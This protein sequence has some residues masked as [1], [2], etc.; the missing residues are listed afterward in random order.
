M[1]SELKIAEIGAVARQN[2]TDLQISMNEKIHE[3]FAGIRSRVAATRDRRSLQQLESRIGIQTGTLATTLIRLF[4][5]G[6]SQVVE[7]SRRSV[8]HSTGDTSWSFA[9]NGTNANLFSVGINEASAIADY[10]PPSDLRNHGRAAGGILGSVLGGGA[11]IALATAGPLGLIIGGL[12][13]VL[14]GDSIGELFSDSGN[15][16]EAS[17][18]EIASLLSAIDSAESSMRSRVDEVL[19]VT[20]VDLVRNLESFRASNEALAEILKLRAE[21]LAITG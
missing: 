1:E 5:A 8:V 13:G 2:L 17:S 6:V 19:R 7:S 21:L 4:H 15:S 16:S 11:G 9:N 20:S 12:L 3:E 14:M 10:R 18:A